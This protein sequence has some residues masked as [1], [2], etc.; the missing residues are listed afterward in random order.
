MNDYKTEPT[1][2]CKANVC[3]TAAER[4]KDAPEVAAI[5]GRRTAGHQH[6]VDPCGGAHAHQRRRRDH[7]H[8]QSARYPVQLHG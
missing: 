8:L 6:R 4:A 1:I 7:L 3:Y 2:T 5:P